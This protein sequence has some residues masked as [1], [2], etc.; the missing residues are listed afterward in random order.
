M[1]TGLS[2]LDFG[3]SLFAALW[4]RNVRAFSLEA[5]TAG[6]R[7]DLCFDLSVE[8]AYNCLRQRVEGSD[9]ELEFVIRCHPLHGDSQKARELVSQ[10]LSFRL[11]FIEVPHGL[12]RLCMSD[13]WAGKQLDRSPVDAEIW[14]EL[15]Q[16]FD[17]DWFLPESQRQFVR[18]RST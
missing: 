14:R 8:Q 18:P 12:L 15:A 17:Y 1:P 9:I 10:L 5:R 3:F 2:D 4:L 6:G 11:A 7:G 16:E 13:D